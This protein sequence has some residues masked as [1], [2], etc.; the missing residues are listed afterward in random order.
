[1]NSRSSIIAIFGEFLTRYPRHFSLL[2]L[3][4][5]LEGAAAAMSV[6]AIVPL[7][8]FMLDPM[9]GKPSRIT[10]LVTSNLDALGWPITFWVFGLLFF[11]ANFLKGLLDV[12]IRYAILRI[13]YLVLRGLYGDALHTFF[14]ARWEFFSGS[15]QGKLLNTL[16]REMITINI[17]KFLSAFGF[18]LFNFLL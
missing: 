16:N 8:D 3:F 7:A 17:N 10:Q 15:D 9:L 13:K 5:V 14:K 6:L 4:L 18:D 12:A 2:F 11:A 1:M